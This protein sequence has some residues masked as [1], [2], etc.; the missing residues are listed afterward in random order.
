MTQPY[1]V[2]IIGSGAG[3]GT[4]A[5]RLAPSGKPHHPNIKRC[6]FARCGYRPRS[7]IRRWAGI[8]GATPHLPIERAMSLPQGMI[9]TMMSVIM[10]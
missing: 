10:R 2:I 3:G 6:S 7:G 9:L 1:D 5:Y 8:R 4:L